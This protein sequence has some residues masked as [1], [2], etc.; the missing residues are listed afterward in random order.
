MSKLYVFAIGGTGSRV[1]RSLTMLLAASVKS[2]YNEIVPIII[3]PDQA[4][5]DM[6][7]TVDLMK[8]YNRIHDELHFTD[9]AKNHFFETSLTPITNNY[10]MSI[11]NGN[12]QSFEDFIDITSI[13]NSSK[14]GEA[15]VRML[16]SE[17]NLASDM[18][19]GFKGN[20]NI[21]SVVLNQFGQSKE[22]ENFASNFSSGDKIF[23]ISSIFGGTGAS[24]FPLLLKTL[25]GCKVGNSDIVKNAP[26]GALSVLPY[27]SINNGDKNRE[28]DSTSFLGKT[29]A[30]L[31]YYTRNISGKGDYSIDNIYYIGDDASSNYDYCE[32]GQNQRNHAHVIEL[33]SALA[34]LDFARYGKRQMGTET[35]EFGLDSL[36][37]QLQFSNLSQK[38]RDAITR[39]M[40]ML[41][42]FERFCENKINEDVSNKTQPWAK[43]LGVDGSMLSTQFGEDLTR[44][45]SEYRSWLSEMAENKRSFMPF[46]LAASD[47]INGVN[48]Y[49][50]KYSIFGHGKGFDYLTDRLNKRS[51]ELKKADGTTTA[52]KMMDTFYEVMEDVVK[53]KIIK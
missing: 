29:R 45:L 5:G 40:T 15:L 14:G 9:S 37:D 39:P 19:V 16:F 8:R 20:P 43:S 1:L 24:G 52:Q 53:D 18:T 41:M 42:L 10:R 2:S 33:F 28:I 38:T 30:A 26:I 12:G 23:I 22:F 51:G 47:P 34:V 13:G 50:V 7:R 35:K 21:G 6:T 49:E 46:E 31:S 27:F 48:G 32:G 11:K 25:R 4:A 36:T 3:D 44:F 17:S